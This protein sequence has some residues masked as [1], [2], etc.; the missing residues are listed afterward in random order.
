MADGIVGLYPAGFTAGTTVLDDFDVNSY[1]SVLDH[2]R[3]RDGYTLDWVYS[4][5]EWQGLHV[6]IEDFPSGAAPVLY[7]RRLEDPRLRT[8]GDYQSPDATPWDWEDVSYRYLNYV[9]PDGTDEGYFQLA[10]LRLLGDRF[11][12][13][14]HAAYGDVAVICDRRAIDRTIESQLGGYLVRPPLWL[15]LRARLLSFGPFVEQGQD[16]VVVRLVTFSRFDGFVRRSFTIDRTGQP[17]ITEND[18]QVLVP[19]DIGIVY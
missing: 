5:G 2:L 3:M 11:Y 18:E 12:V 1:F 7:A 16:T 14:W 17:R 9:D 4:T 13:Y 15:H 8:L 19:Y 10:L 6:V